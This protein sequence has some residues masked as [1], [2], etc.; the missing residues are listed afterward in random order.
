V[1]ALDIVFPFLLLGWYVVLYQR[2]LTFMLRV[3]AFLP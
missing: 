3:G 2:G 1:I